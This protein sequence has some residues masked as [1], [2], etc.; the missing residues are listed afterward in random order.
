MST[1]RVVESL[2]VTAE[3]SRSAMTVAPAE[4]VTLA[5]GRNPVP[6][7]VRVPPE[8]IVA[9][10]TPAREGGGT[11]VSALGS[12][13]EQPSGLVTVTSCWP[14]ARPLRTVISIVVASTSFTSPAGSLVPPTVTVAPARKSLPVSVTLVV[15]AWSHTV[16]GAMLVSVGGATMWSAFASVCEQ[17]SARITCTA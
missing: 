16:A 5:P 15:S 3:P 1:V 17:P 10:A 12:V 14:S 8:Q 9:G 11:T 7:R 6:V 13:E 2:T 4:S